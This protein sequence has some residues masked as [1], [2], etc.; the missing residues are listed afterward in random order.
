MMGGSAMGLRIALLAQCITEACAAQRDNREYLSAAGRKK[1]VNLAA[2]LRALGCRVDILS[3]SYAKGNHRASTEA[4]ADGISVHHVPTL[5][6]PGRHT[7]FKRTLAGLYNARWLWRQRHEVDLIVIYN[8][9]AEFALP[10][11][12]AQWLLGIAFVLD[13]EDGLHLVRRYRSAFYRALE[14][15][16]YRRCSGA[17]R[18]NPHLADRMLQL[19]VDKPGIV[20]HSCFNGASVQHIEASPGTHDELLYA[21]TY[22][23][24][25]GF[26]ELLQYIRHMPPGY[27]LNICGRAGPAEQAQIEAACA[28]RP[29]VRLLG[30]VPDAELEAL[31][32]RARAVIV[33]N[34]VES[35][36]NRTNFPSKLYDYLS[37]GKII[38]TTANP[39]LSDYAG[40]S[41]MLQLQSIEHELPHLAERLAGRRFVRAEVDALHQ[42]ILDDLRGLLEAAARRR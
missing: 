9:H 28:G 34:D 42:R 27:L 17:I 40:L 15:A 30:F 1:C 29:N 36:F 20:V 4:L 13:H 6:L 12:F 22:S 33:L 19:G 8:Y 5:A 3:N 2:Y 16:V 7:I 10:A 41:C 14:R 39:L 18:V 11:L 24:G 37:A 31:K 32:R 35:E 23:K 26:G 25:F 21:G 38:V